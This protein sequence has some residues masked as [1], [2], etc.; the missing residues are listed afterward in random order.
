MP[1]ASHKWLKAL[2]LQAALAVLIYAGAGA[3]GAFAASCSVTIDAVNFGNVDTLSGEAADA[4]AQV[5]I[6][7][8]DVSATATAVTVCGNLNAGSGGATATGT[9]TMPSGTN[10]LDY[11]F[12]GDSDHGT[13]WG[14]YNA[15]A[16]GQP[17]T[18]RLAASDGA[19]SRTVTL[20]G[21]VSAR[22][23]KA[24][25]GTYLSS[26]TAADATFYYQEGS[27]LDCTAP[28]S[29]T[30]AQVSF[31]TQAIV[32]ANCLVTVE[33]ID[34]GVHGLIDSEVTATGGVNVTCTPGTKY[35]IAMDGGLTGATNPEQRLMRSGTNTIAYGLYADAAHTTPWSA[36][37]SRLVSGTGA[38]AVQSIA[39]FGRVAPQSAA[40]GQYSD[41]VVVTITYQ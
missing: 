19:A 24:A 33:D 1:Y 23:A 35:T 10:V 37:G 28:T 12:Y 8:S 9:R 20:Y 27:T 18:I 5:S 36:T 11:E 2:L 30:L 22:Q 16:L 6:S 25:T 4:S 32:A 13:R 41:T 7:C 17:Q 38:G 21:V 40:I 3:G 15:T 29:A 31:S 26:F 14:A 34:F 39:V